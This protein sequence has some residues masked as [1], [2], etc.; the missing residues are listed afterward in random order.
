M[1]RW[2]L[3]LPDGAV[4]AGSGDM[5]AVQTIVTVVQGIAA[6]G[7][8][9]GAKSR[10]AGLETA[11]EAA[12]PDLGREN[13]A[14][15][16]RVDFATDAAL[17]ALRAGVPDAMA[18]GRALEGLHAV[19]ADRS[20][21]ADGGSGVVS[22]GGI[23]V[24]DALGHPLPCEAMRALATDDCKGLRLRWTGG[25]VGGLIARATERCKA[26]DDRKPDALGAAA[27]R[28]LAKLPLRQN[29]NRKSDADRPAGPCAT[30][31]V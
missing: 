29:G 4:A 28:A 6:T 14:A 11:W 18:V 25:A 15:W 1:A 2:V 26:D 3:L 23:A 21:G 31:Y 12:R 27:L 8:Q 7:D 13:R 30:R 5:Q 22:I 16:G 19:L 24:T 9:A 20:A 10:I 17:S